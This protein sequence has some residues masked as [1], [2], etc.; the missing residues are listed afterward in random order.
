MEAVFASG[1]EFLRGEHLDPS[2]HE[3]PEAGLQV[4]TRRWEPPPSRERT[5]NLG[6]T[7]SRPGSS[8]AI[9]PCHLSDS[10]TRAW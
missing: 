8:P 10:L 9:V 1:L 3:D 7:I 5:H 4:C 2:H 6:Q